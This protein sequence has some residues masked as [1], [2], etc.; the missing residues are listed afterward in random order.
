MA[1]SRA[2]LREA[3]RERKPYGDVVECGEVRE[4]QIV[5]ENDSHGTCFR[6]QMNVGGGVVEDFPVQLDTA[7]SDWDQAG[8]R[9]QQGGF[10]GP[11][12]P[13]EGDDL[14]LLGPKVDIE[15]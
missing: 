3:P 6:R 10:T 5:L 2:A 14:R 11:V 12:R 7:V 1:S 8:E 9:P 15:I 13:N 4:Q